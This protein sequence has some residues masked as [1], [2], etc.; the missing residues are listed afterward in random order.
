MAVARTT[1]DSGAQPGTTTPCSPSPGWPCSSRIA[2][3]VAGG[4]AWGRRRLTPHSG[5]SPQISESPPARVS[6]ATRCEVPVQLANFQ[7]GIDR[8]MFLI[9]GPC[10][11]EGDT[12]T[13]EI[14]GKL[15]EITTRLGV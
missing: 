8:P 1:T 15:K 13:Q 2:P 4:G 14:A 3:T 10:V 11:I 7:V 6:C 12:L 5:R 9:A